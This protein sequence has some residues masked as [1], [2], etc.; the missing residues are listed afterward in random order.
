MLHFG[1]TALLAAFAAGVVAFSSPCVF[2]LIP[3]Y[4]SFVSGVSFDELG[5]RPRRV[6]TST[7]AFVLGFGAIFVLLG[8]GAGWFGNVLLVNRRPLQIVAGVFIALAGLLY[9]GLPVP[10]WLLA[11]RRIEV[12]SERK[13]A[14]TA[15]L[16]GAA[17]GIGWTPCIGPTLAAILALAA[18]ESPTKGAVLLGAYTLGLGI[19][20]LLFGLL[21]TRALGILR[22]MRSNWRL[23]SLTSGAL[24]V[25]FGT[26][27]ASGE[28]VRLT[29]RLS[30]FTGWQI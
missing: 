9:A 26:L 16:A 17:F 28:L 15:T 12:R 24:L 4:L 30:R 29:A 18:G 6:V 19:P 11:E 25:M 13:T 27:L 2:P 14:A 20:F 22:W 23:V 3:G 21:F 5:S 7:A 1:P 8:A 10:R